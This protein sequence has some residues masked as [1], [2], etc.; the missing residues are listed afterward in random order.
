MHIPYKET[1]KTLMINLF[2]TV[3]RKLLQFWTSD[4]TRLL[5]HVIYVIYALCNMFSSEAREK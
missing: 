3:R 5:Y 4:F 2:K 1:T